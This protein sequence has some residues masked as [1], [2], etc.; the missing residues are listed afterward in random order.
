MSTFPSPAVA[1]RPDHRPVPAQERRTHDRND[2]RLQLLRSMLADRRWS[3]TPVVR[4]RLLQILAGAAGLGYASEWAWMTLAEEIARY[5]LYR[6]TGQ[7]ESA[8]LE[9][10]R[11]RREPVAGIGR[12]PLA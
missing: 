9:W 8:A 2:D 5:L 12:R 10:Q 6:R 11:P 7:R 3:C 1:C 4:A